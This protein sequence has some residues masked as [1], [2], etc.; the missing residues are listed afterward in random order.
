M[1]IDFPKNLITSKSGVEF[2]CFV[3]RMTKRQKNK[4]IIWNFRYTKRI[5]TN[6]LSF[7]GLILNRSYKHKNNIILIIRDCEGE[8]CKYDTKILE[9]LFNKYSKLKNNAINYR[10][11]NLKNIDIDVHKNK[12]YMDILSLNL[13]NYTQ[14]KILISE[15]IANINMHTELKECTISGYL[16]VKEE[17]IVLSI[18]NMG[19]T[20]RQNIEETSKFEFNN[21]IDAIIWALKKTNTTRKS[22][23]SGGLGLYLLRKYL[24]NIKGTGSVISGKSI[25]QLKEGFYNEKNVNDMII[26]PHNKIE[27]R[28]SFFPGTLITIRIPYVLNKR[29]D[30][31][32]TEKILQN[33]SLI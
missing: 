23:E 21:D 4:K 29:I 18:C 28:K 5:E 17:N 33:F 19:K 22:D 11:L 32:N 20:I 26:D 30:K 9:I 27:M 16:D 24:Y 1:I 25:I 7:L 10:Y 3:W 8:L 2:L 31:D 13:R 6:L 14:V 12:L 15:F